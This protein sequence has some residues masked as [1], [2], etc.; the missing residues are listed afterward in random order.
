MA[1][2]SKGSTTHVTSHFF[3]PLMKRASLMRRSRLCQVGQQVPTTRN[4]SVAFCG[5]DRCCNFCHCCGR[6]DGP[7][8][9]QY[10]KQLIGTGTDFQ[11]HHPIVPIPVNEQK[12]WFRRRTVGPVFRA[13]YSLFLDQL[14]LR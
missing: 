7:F 9:A 10:V 13:D 6:V 5:C 1:F 14:R 12:T 8:M 11:E 3:V 2:R 4:E